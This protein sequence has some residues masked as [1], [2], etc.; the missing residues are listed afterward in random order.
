DAGEERERTRGRSGFEQDLGETEADARSL[1]G[2]LEEHAVP[3]DERSRDHARR[4]RPR[5]VPGRDDDPDPA[6]LVAIRIR[7]PGHLHHRHARAEPQRLAAVVLAEIDRL[8]D[9]G[10]GLLLWL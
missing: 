9:V 3:R 6:R 5:E 8:A 4:N 10:V 1:L 2:R 7:L